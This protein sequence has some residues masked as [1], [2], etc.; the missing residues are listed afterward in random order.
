MNSMRDW[1]SHTIIPREISCELFPRKRNCTGTGRKTGRINGC[2]QRQFSKAT[3]SLAKSHVRFSIFNEEVGVCTG[4][5]NFCRRRDD[6]LTRGALM[7]RSML[8]TFSDPKPKKR[9]I[10]HPPKTKRLQCASLVLQLVKTFSSSVA[11]LEFTVTHRITVTTPTRSH[12]LPLACHLEVV[13]WFNQGS[14][15]KT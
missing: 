13:K 10:F 11:D 5:I 12:L 14:N 6:V 8:V 1:L 4:S 9:H 7:G 3:G 2:E 15:A